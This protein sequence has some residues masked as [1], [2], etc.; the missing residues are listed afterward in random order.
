MADIK[1]ILDAK[2]VEGE[3]AMEAQ[4]RHMYIPP[5]QLEEHELHGRIV[6]YV[7]EY[8]R[9]HPDQ[10]SAW[11]VDEHIIEISIKPRRI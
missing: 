8:F 2:I 10:G 7:D 4:R 11:V 3:M 6:L 1:A 9:R 5:R